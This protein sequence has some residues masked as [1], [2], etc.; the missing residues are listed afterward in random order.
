MSIEH[1]V[2][3]SSLRMDRRL[4]HRLLDRFADPQRVYE[5][6][7]PELR[8]LAL[9]QRAQRIVLQTRDLR[10]AR[11]VISFLCKTIS[12]SSRCRTRH[13]LTA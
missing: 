13:I 12:A 2:W 10:F 9:G 11:N 5:A 3:L 4:M 6:T 8:D 1:W 7:E